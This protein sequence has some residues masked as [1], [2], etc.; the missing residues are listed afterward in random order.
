MCRFGGFEYNMVK[1]EYLINRVVLVYKGMFKMI[2][3][4]FIFRK[5]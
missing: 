5:S 1:L 2:G 4:C 3:C